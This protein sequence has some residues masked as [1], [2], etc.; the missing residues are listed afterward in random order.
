MPKKPQLNL[1]L[2]GDPGAGKA[3]QAKHFA[4]KYNMFD[5]DMGRE[6]TL[7]REKS[8]A[9]SN[10]LQK[11]YDKGNLAPTK[12]VRDI[13]RDKF[14]QLS[15]EQG[16]LF[17]GFPKML[18]EAKI[19]NTLLKKTNRTKPLVLY[20][21]ITMDEMAL[22]VLSRKGYSDTKYGK[23][24]MDTKEGI[25]NRMRYYR[26]NIQQVIEYFSSVY[27]FARIDGMGT[28]TEVRQRIQKAIDFYLKNY[29]Q[30]NKS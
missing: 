7:L 4:K 5:F 13:I 22:R 25:K 3:T 17:D 30:I 11:N 6:L 12:M 19:V 29:D 1:I 26:T 15:P 9:A 10:T 21:H 23:R 16:I 14:D 18:G 20:L 27:T 8:Q 2:L 24:H 28:R